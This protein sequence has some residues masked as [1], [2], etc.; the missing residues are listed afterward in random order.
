M[1]GTKTLR[2]FNR[3]DIL[4]II[5]LGVNGLFATFR[6]ITLRHYAQCRVLVNV[7]MSA[8]VAPQ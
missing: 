7:L 1:P 5:T 4:L 8:A 3:V 2:S 6:I